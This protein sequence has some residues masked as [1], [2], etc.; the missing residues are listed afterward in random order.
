MGLDLVSWRLVREVSWMMEV[1]DRGM[2]G[3]GGYEV[4][5]IPSKTV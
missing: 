1:V 4:T 3:S 5:D 2:G